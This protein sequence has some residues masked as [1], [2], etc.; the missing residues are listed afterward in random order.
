MFGTH[1]QS[2][3]SAGFQ[4]LSSQFLTSPMQIAAAAALSAQQQYRST[5]L[6][7][8][9]Y[10]KGI[11]SQH[12]PDQSGRSQQLKSPGANQD[13]L[14]SVFNSGMFYILTYIFLQKGKVNLHPMNCAYWR[15]S[16]EMQDI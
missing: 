13:V 3:A 8:Q 9:N 2:H 16:R 10:L 14:A 11:G 12:I 1:N 6:P 4:G 7:N 15:Y 5:N